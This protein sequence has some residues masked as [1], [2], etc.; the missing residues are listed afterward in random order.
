[1]VTSR[2]LYL[3][4]FILL[5]AVSV[6]AQDPEPADQQ[7]YGEQTIRVFLDCG[8]GCDESYIRSEITFVNFTRDKRDADVHLLITR[9][10]TGGGGRQYTLKFLGREQ[11]DQKSDTLHYLS[12]ESDT[13]DERRTGLNKYIKVGLLPYVSEVSNLDNFEIAFIQPSKSV[14]TTAREDKWNNW[15]FEI[16]GNMFFDGEESQSSIFLSGD[17]SAERVTEAWKIELFY[18]RSYRRRKF[19]RDEG[20]DVFITESQFFNGEVIKSIS[21][22]WSAG[23]LTRGRSSTRENLDAGFAAAP[24]LEYN[25][26]PYAEF[27]ERE[28]SFQYSIQPIYNN[29]EDSTIFNKTREWI[30]EQEF[31]GNMEFTQPWGEIEGRMVASNFLNDFSKNRFFVDLEFD[32]RITRGLSLNLSGR[33]S[34]INDQ[35][36]LSKEGVTDEEQLL[37]LRQQST[38]YSFGGSFGFEYTFGSVFNNVVN[39]RF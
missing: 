7:V 31:S 35:V 28:I 36:F 13:D 2:F 27:N 18:D 11:F 32:I 21:R 39:P 20:E 22:H 3:I 8:R 26:F 6:S 17:A 30:F 1:M 5:L 24:A 14:Q 9:E 16:G 38:S 29:Y 37:N 10:R 19:D 34:I 25:I 4:T 33:Y 12:L 23:L 15:I